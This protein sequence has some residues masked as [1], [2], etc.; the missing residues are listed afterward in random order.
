MAKSIWNPVLSAVRRLR[1]RWGLHEA[2]IYRQWPGIIAYGL[3]DYKGRVVAYTR[4]ERTYERTY[5]AGEDLTAGF[6]YLD[7]DGKLYQA[8]TG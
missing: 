3:I 6:V 5:V 4:I 7:E 8:K 1:V 2:E